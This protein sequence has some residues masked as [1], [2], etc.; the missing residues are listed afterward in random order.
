MF[1][2]GVDCYIMWKKVILYVIKNCLHFSLLPAVNTSKHLFMFSPHISR[3]V[4]VLRIR[5]PRRLNILFMIMALYF[6]YSLNVLLIC[7][8]WFANHPSTDGSPIGRWVRSTDGTIYIIGLHILMWLFVTYNVCIICS[9]YYIASYAGKAC[10]TCTGVSADTGI[11]WNLVINTVCFNVN[12]IYQ[13][14]ECG[15]YSYIMFV[16]WSSIWSC[17]VSHVTCGIFTASRA[18]PN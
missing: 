14:I 3:S 11:R 6:F 12:L 15:P 4:K 5:V 1:C 18:Y 2:Y 16:A 8:L 13:A 7:M 9:L 17:H 10:I